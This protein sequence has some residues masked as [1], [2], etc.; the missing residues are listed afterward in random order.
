MIKT[1]GEL[2]EE[3]SKFPKDMLI[4]DCYNCE[5]ESVEYASVFLCDSGRFDAETTDVVKI[6]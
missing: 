4:V 2:I 1:V 6:F 5:I 3:L